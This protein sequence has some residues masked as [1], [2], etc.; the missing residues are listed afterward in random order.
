MHSA[1]RG[2]IVQTEMQGDGTGVT[3][4]KVA[5]GE[6]ILKFSHAAPAQSRMSL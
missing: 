5:T 2:S 6:V 1:L 4:V 3:A